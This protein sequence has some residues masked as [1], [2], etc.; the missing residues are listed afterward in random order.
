MLDAELRQ[1]LIAA[2]RVAGE[3]QL[4]LLFGSLARGQ[5]RPDSDLDLAI[6]LGRPL[7]AADK[8]ALVE[9]LALASGRPVDLVDLRTAGVPLIA[10]ILRDGLRLA[11]GV[12]AHGALMARHVTDAEDFL[13]VYRRLL[14]AR[15]AGWSRP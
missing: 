1:R 6:D 3:P 10:S 9:A 12:E 11:G 2:S 15:L 13:P 7:A 8:F 5:A 14:D 4:V